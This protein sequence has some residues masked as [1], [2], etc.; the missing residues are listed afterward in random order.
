M[1]ILFLFF[2]QEA[3]CQ[4]GD[5]IE[6]ESNIDRLQNNGTKIQ[7]KQKG[8]KSKY[9]KVKILKRVSLKSRKT[10]APSKVK[11][12]T[13]SVHRLPLTPKGKKE[14]KRQFILRPPHLPMFEPFQKSPFM[15]MR[16]PPLTQKTVVTTHI[17]R[18]P[19]AIP[20]NSLMNH[21][22][23]PFMNEQPGMH[24]PFQMLE[25][26]NMMKQ[27]EEDEDEGK[28]LILSSPSGLFSWYFTG[29]LHFSCCIKS[30]CYLVDYVWLHSNSLLRLGN[31]KSRY[32]TATPHKRKL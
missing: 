12:S 27:Y 16:P 9:H 6:E 4:S 32:F 31:P 11:S 10:V 19:I 21:F 7:T 15:M 29:F 30:I 14:Q 17:P 23:H 2:A 26:P 3:S 25:N 5:A 18:P 22:L 28:K 20:Y 1:G 24:S 8:S 13:K